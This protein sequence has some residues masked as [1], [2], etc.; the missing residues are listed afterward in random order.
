MR[1]HRF[2]SFRSDRQLEWP[3][4]V[5]GSY[6]VYSGFVALDRRALPECGEYFDDG[7]DE[8]EVGLEGYEKLQGAKITMAMMVM[9]RTV[10]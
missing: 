5:G 8:E 2:A 1:D 6:S 3:T 4:S 10:A 7:G 9:R